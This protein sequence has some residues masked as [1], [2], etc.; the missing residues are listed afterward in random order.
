MKTEDKKMMI[1][2]LELEV[3][4]EL[5]SYCTQSDLNERELMNELV[6]YFL[7][8]GLKML[9]TMRKGYKE[10]ARI[11]LDICSEFDECETEVTSLI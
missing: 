6:H 4:E 11:N 9:D 8:D 3:Y 2:D 5:V 1:V 7:I 10:M